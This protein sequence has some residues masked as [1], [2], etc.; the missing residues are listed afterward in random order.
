[1]LKRRMS[2]WLQIVLGGSFSGAILFGC[3][4]HLRLMEHNKLGIGH[5]RDRV[6][7]YYAIPG[8]FGALAG[9][10]VA[11]A[12]LLKNT[13]AGAP[14]GGRQPSLRLGRGL[15]GAVVGAL[16]GAA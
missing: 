7:E 4:G 6:N 2:I 15:C 1:M 9:G 16:G 8:L 5:S 11:I 3:L 12:Y 13:A 14:A 10:V